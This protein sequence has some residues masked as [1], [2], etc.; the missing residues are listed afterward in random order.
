[1]TPRTGRPTNNPKTHETRIRMSDKDVQ[2]LEWCSKE[3][4]LPKSEI[5]RMGIRK[6]YNE[7]KK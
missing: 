4:G 3:T 6:V 5:M 1:M 2:M 7:L